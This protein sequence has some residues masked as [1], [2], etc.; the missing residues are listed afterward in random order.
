MLAAVDQV[1]LDQH[2]R[3]AHDKTKNHALEPL[4]RTQPQTTFSSPVEYS[5]SRPS[6]IPLS[7]MEKLPVELLAHIFLLASHA[8]RPTDTGSAEGDNLPFSPENIPTSLAISAVNRQWRQIALSTPG[9]WSSICVV[10]EDIDD[11][12]EVDE[13]SRPL[14]DFQYPTTVNIEHINNSL[15]RS[16]SS[17]I[18][19]IIDGRDPEWDFEERE[20]RCV[21]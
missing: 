6:F 8:E 3:G 14:S 17:P 20:P 19:I 12:M 2:D 7:P 5:H 1:F 21:A 9:L 4:F 16:G 13:T 18:D 15:V 10:W 11:S